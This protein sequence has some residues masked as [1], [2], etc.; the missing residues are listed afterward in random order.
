MGG[1]VTA[2]CLGGIQWIGCPSVPGGVLFGVADATEVSLEG[3]RPDRG[4]TMVKGLQAIL[5]QLDTLE[6]QAQDEAGGV[7]TEVFGDLAEAA[8]YVR[9]AV[10]RLTQQ[11][12]PC[13]S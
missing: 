13:A 12:A 6:A 10:K 5:I 8:F 3:P 4:Q 11:E 1:H 7:H 9:S 2:P